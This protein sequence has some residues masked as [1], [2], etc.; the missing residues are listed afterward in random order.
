MESSKV[1]EDLPPFY[2]QTRFAGHMDMYSDVETVA[3]YFSDHQNWFTYCAEPMKTEPLGDNGYILVI[4]QYGALG[5]AVEPKMAVILEP[6]VNGKYDMRSVPIPEHHHEAYQVEYQASME[7]NSFTLETMGTAIEKVYKKQGITTLPSVITQVTWQLSL[8]VAVK[9]PKFIH[10]LPN[11]AI[12]RTGDRL[13]T[14]IVR[15][16]SPRLTFKVQKYFH[17]QHDLPMPPKEGRKFQRVLSGSQ[18]ISE[19]N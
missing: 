8:N 6:P 19:D 12:Q 3:E 14:E 15:Q 18:L 13:L 5:Y 16:V 1:L 11:T 7:L 10:K 4:G 2:F 9:F 17:E